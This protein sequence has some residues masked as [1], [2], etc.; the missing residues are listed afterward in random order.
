MAQLFLLL[1]LLLLLLIPFSGGRSRNRAASP[2]APPTSSQIQPSIQA[3][4]NPA[5]SNAPNDSGPS[6]S[7]AAQEIPTPVLLPGLLGLSTKI[8]LKRAKEEQETP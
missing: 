7:A 1:P 5:A 6:I 4:N 8:L 3:A 2:P